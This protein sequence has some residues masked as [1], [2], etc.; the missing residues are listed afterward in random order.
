[1]KR[2]ILAGVLACLTAAPAFAALSPKAE[3]TIKVIKSIAD[4]PAKM[5][6]FCTLA[7]VLDKAGDKSDPATDKKVDELLAQLGKEFE[8]A[9]DAGEEFGET[10]EDGKAY[11]AAVNELEDKCP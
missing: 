11:D 6:I 2:I 4:D 5:K 1:M 9:W 7:D 8:D 10:T 3:Q